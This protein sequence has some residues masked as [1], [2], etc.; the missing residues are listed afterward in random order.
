MFDVKKTL[1]IILFFAR[2]NNKKGEV[3]YIKVLKLL[4]LADKLFLKRYGTT[5]SGDHYV[6]MKLWPVASWVFNVMK[7][8]ERFGNLEEKINETIKINAETKTLQALQDLDPDYLSE[9]ELATLAEI[10][11]VFGKDSY[12]K[13][14]DICHSFDEWAKH[15][16]NIWN[17][18]IPME[19][20]DFFAPSKWENKIFE[21][22]E[23]QVALSK[24]I[25]QE[26][27]QY[28]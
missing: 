15:K 19:F 25:Y 21:M 27:A 12:S 3:E 13:L 28:V 5:I 16:N 9:L 24:A 17:S 23:D 2:N 11:K 10:V 4:F 22:D 6:A 1:Q 26:Q 7:E 20:L 8:P 18:C 14:I